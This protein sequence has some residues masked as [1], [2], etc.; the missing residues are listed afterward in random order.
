[1]IFVKTTD[2]LSF[3]VQ[4]GQAI[5]GHSLTECWVAG[6]DATNPE[7]IPYF[8]AQ[9]APRMLHPNVRTIIP[10]EFNRAQRQ[11][12][13]EAE[14][15]SSPLPSV[16]EYSQVVQTTARCFARMNNIVSA[17]DALK[18]DFRTLAGFAEKYTVEKVKTKPTEQ[19]SFLKEMNSL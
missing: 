5:T 10:F 6:E 4:I 14:P 11:S 19:S 12:A 13:A 17:V 8:N 9:I 3:L 18:G 1:M 7:F 15:L 2:G 16:I